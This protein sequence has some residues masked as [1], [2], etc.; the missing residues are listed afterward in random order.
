MQPP[1]GFEAAFDAPCPSCG[2]RVGDHKPE[3]HLEHLTVWLA[4]P[5]RTVEEVIQYHIGV[6]ES[7]RHTMRIGLPGWAIDNVITQH[8]GQ[9]AEV[10]KRRTR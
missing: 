7:I 5:D 4:D 10:L 1:P 3:E 6:L 8:S 2:N 9:Q